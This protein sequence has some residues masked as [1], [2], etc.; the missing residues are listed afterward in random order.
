M[1]NIYLFQP[2]YSVDLN[3][4]KSYWLP[5]SSGC[6]WAYAKTFPEIATNFNLK[7]II[8][9]R[10]DHDVILD[11]L[12]NPAICGFS[13]YVWNERYSLNLAK[14]I[15]QRWPDCLIVFGG[16]QTH[17][18]YLS[19]DFIDSIVLGEG[20]YSFV[21]LLKDYLNNS[22]I[23]SLY[24][25][26]RVDNLDLLPNPYTS[27][28]FD[29]IIEKYPDYSW[30]TTFET[31]RGCPYQCT[32]C[33]WGSLTYNKV[34][35]FDLEYV[36]QSI[37]WIVKHNV[38]YLIFADANFGIFKE[39]D[40]EIARLLV[41]TAGETP[42][43]KLELLNISFAKNSTNIVFEIAK[44]LEV[45]MKG[46]TFAMQSVNNE[47]LKLI[48]RDNM[49]VNKLSEMLRL[50]EET[51]V[52][53]YSELILGLP[54][55]TLESWKHG[56]AELLELGQH[57]NIDIWFTQLLVNAD[58]GSP[59]SVKKFKIKTVK[60]KNYI[61]MYNPEEDHGEENQE[62]IELI[63]QT[64]TMTTED[65]V[66]AYMY[67]WLIIHFHINGYSQLLARYC[68]NFHDVTYRQFYD[69]L[70]ENV[71]NDKDIGE[72]YKYVHQI[73]LD[74][75]R[76]GE[77]TDIGNLRGHNIR[78]MSSEYLFDHRV[79]LINLAIQTAK[80]LAPVSDDIIL[81]QQNAIYEPTET[82]PKQI[83][84]NIDV[85]KWEKQPV[86]YQILNT[87]SSNSKFNFYYARRKGLL[88]NKFVKIA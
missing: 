18:G 33:D 39:R 40:L 8:F 68:K 16:A 55:E 19:H 1:K 17:S 70:L 74:Y 7:E 52:N 26:S 44:I 10:E 48:K 36:K 73:T 72:H 81:L 71:L 13:C 80:E 20:E 64:D 60:A 32:F 6:I 62:I 66:D 14:K 86:Q 57:T 76:T 49:E 58:L 47:T 34:K 3:G 69:R 85:I 22:S 38:N 37:D 59:E 28:V 31:N 82:Y 50:S 30:A 27:N 54:G 84:A 11:R 67:S 75:L 46:L 56:M 77:L 83:Q 87:I 15:K 2:Q 35:K 65:M 5:Y 51:N 43:C 9:K 41:K 12:D 29:H 61:S 63:S 79:N 45:Y 78:F 25:K 53:S 42:T 21:K 4:Q 88:K 23:E 24:P